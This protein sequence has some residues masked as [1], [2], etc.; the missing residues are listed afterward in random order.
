[1]IRMKYLKIVVLAT[2]AMVALS[3]WDTSATAAE[4]RKPT[5]GRRL[6]FQSV[7]CSTSD[8]LGLTGGTTDWLLPRSDTSVW[9]ASAAC[10]RTG[11]EIC[12]ARPSAQEERLR[13]R[14]FREMAFR[15]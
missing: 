6:P 10:A 5:G 11:S 1:M 12:D 14:G 8:M 3:S 15:S 2:I 13:Y 7:L 4:T 9:S